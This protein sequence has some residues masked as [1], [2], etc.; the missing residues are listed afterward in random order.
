LSFL[1]FGLS[2]PSP[3]L[4]QTAPAFHSELW[5][6]VDF[7]ASEV[8]GGNADK[9]FLKEGEGEARLLVAA[10]QDPGNPD[11]CSQ[12]PWPGGTTV[13]GPDSAVPESATRFRQYSR[14]CHSG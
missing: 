13:P 3:A 1:A 14:V 2:A 11:N 7:Q 12:T 5:K 6:T 4:W 10:V 8:L 9:R